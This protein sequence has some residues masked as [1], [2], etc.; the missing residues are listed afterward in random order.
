MRKY[1]IPNGGRFYK[2][3]L[4]THTTVSDGRLTPEELKDEYKKRGFSVV[5]YTDHELIVPHNDLRDADFLPITAYEIAVADGKWGPFTKCYH[6]NIYFKDKDTALSRTFCARHVSSKEHM[7][8]LIT[9][10]MRAYGTESREYTKEFIQW[11]VDTAREEGAIV[12]YNHP[13]WSL[14]DKDDYSGLRGFFGVEWHNSSS[15]G[16][17]MID[18]IQPI[19][20]LLLEGERKCYPLATDDC[21]SL[22]DVG[23]GFVMVKAERLEYDDIFDALDRGDLYSS[24]GPEIKELYVEDGMLV[25]KTSPVKKIIGFTDHRHT[26]RKM[27]GEGE[28][29]TEA[30]LSLETFIRNVGLAPE[31]RMPFVRMDVIDE[32]GRHA[33]SRAYFADEFLNVDGIRKNANN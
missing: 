30:S 27:A 24:T 26:L 2:V 4:H 22:K 8:A 33:Y 18:A 5:A 19:Q 25:I 11:L 10:E 16:I 7:Q 15:S 13:V 28:Y 14:Q 12:S 21:H 9:D 6:L 32:Y 23:R 31:G 20:D 17:G 3:A 1:L 29:I